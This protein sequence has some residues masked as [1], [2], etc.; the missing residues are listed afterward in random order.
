METNILNITFEQ[1]TA[2][3]REL[4]LQPN[5]LDILIALLAIKSKEEEVRELAYKRMYIIKHTIN[6]NG[7]N[8]DNDLF[9][10]LQ[11]H[12]MIKDAGVQNEDIVI[13]PKVYDAFR[14]YSIDTN[15]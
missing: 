11:N 13:K 5:E 3:M 4:Y 6:D 1:I 7:G 12:K 2:L 15:V 9:T 14:K 10:S 8:Y